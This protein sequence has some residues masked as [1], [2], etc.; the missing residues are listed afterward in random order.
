M[1]MQGTFKS[2]NP[3]KGF[4][5]I[6]HNGQDVFFHKSSIVGKPPKE[7]DILTFNLEPSPKNPAQML[8]T[9]VM[10]GTQ[11]GNLQGKVKSYNDFKGFGF[12][13]YQGQS[14]FVHKGEIIG[15]TL[16][17]GDEVWFDISPS[18]KNDGKTVCTN[19]VGGTGP[20]PG[21]GGWGGGK[22]G[23]MEAMFGAMMA[24]MKGGPYGKGKGK[25][26]GW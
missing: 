6:I 3:V 2:F 23:G 14:Y 9:N 13:D 12:I 19:V 26:K 22:G 1:A 24:M 7:G 17:E 8:A 11:G 16:Q 18:P 5:F 15:N 25:G 10:G 20:A 21:T 4:G